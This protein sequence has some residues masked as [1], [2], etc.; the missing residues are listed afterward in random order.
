MFPANFR[1]K[2]LRASRV[3]IAGSPSPLHAG[4]GRAR[5]S[6]GDA[7]AGSPRCRAAPLGAPR[8]AGSA[9][10][11]PPAPPLTP[12][13]VFVWSGGAAPARRVYRHHL[14]R[15][16]TPGMQIPHLHLNVPANFYGLQ[17]HF[18]I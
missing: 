3:A 1:K 2:N 4:A 5:S 7:L 13:T 6:A 9:G 8:S 12:G 14:G 16:Y 17:L 18:T 11:A 15:F 10:G